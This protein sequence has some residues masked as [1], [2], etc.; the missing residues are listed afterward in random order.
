MK[1]IVVDFSKNTV[2]TALIDD[3]K[4]VEIIVENRD[5]LSEIGNIYVGIVKNILPS[6][7]IFIDI[8]KDK[9]AF[10]HINDAKEQL[11][12]NNGKLLIKQGDLMAIQVIKDASGSKGAVVTS[13]ICIKSE[14]LVIYKSEQLQIGV[15]KKI[16]DDKIRAKLKKIALDNLEESF[17]VIMRTNSEE[18]TDEML[19]EEFVVS[20]SKYKDLCEKTKYMK[21]PVLVNKDSYIL[22]KVFENL[23]TDDVAEII[24]NSE[25]DLTKVKLISKSI[26]GK[27]LVKL[28]LGEAPI[29]DDY[30]IETQIQKALHKKIWLNTGGFIVIEETEAA[31]IIDVNTGKYSGKKNYKNTILKVNL[32]AGIEAARQIRLRNLSGIIIIDFIDMMSSKDRSELRTCLANEFK[33]DRM[34]VTIVGMTHLGLMQL[35]RKKT[36]ESLSSVLMQTCKNCRGIGK[37]L[38]EVYKEI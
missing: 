20:I 17:S 35:T 29:F 19:K 36:R 4:L 24:I 15:S 22:D 8:G 31:T 9:N 6:Q 2:R 12:T 10:L 14:C 23:L 5:K 30:F 37:V 3:G 27:D 16:E 11:L 32:E 25:Q 7:F 21:A 18:K 13:Q 26:I 28:Y 33:K 38:K 1:K 34:H